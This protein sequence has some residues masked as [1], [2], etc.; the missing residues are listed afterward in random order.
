L[1][2]YGAN[3]AGLDAFI[4]AMEGCRTASLLHSACVSGILD[5]PPGSYPNSIAPGN[6]IPQTSATLSTCPNIVR[7]SAH[8]TL[9]GM[10]KP[11]GGGGI[12]DNVNAPTVTNIGLH[13]ADGTGTNMYDVEGAQNPCTI[14]SG[15]SPCPGTITGIT[16]ISVNT[17]ALESLTAGPLQHIDLTDGYVSPTLA[18]GSGCLTI[19]AGGAHPEC[20]APQVGVD[21]TG[22]WV[23]PNFAHT[24]P[25]TV[26]YVPNNGAG[27]GS[28][29]LNTYPSGTTTN[30]SA[31][32]YLQYEPQLIGSYVAHQAIFPIVLCNQVSISGVINC[33][34]T[35]T[36]GP[37]N[38]QFQYLA[39]TLAPGNTNTGQV[40]IETGANAAVNATSS[41]TTPPFAE[42]CY[43]NYAHHIDFNGMLVYGDW[44]S[45]MVGSTSIVN[46]VEFNGCYYCSFTDSQ[47]TQ[48]VD[49]GSESH[50]IYLGGN[51]L[52]I[53]NNRIECCSIRIFSGGLDQPRRW[54]QNQPNTD[55]QIGRNY[56]G[57][58]YSWL[59]MMKVPAAN[60]NF[61]GT[62]SV[63]WKNCMEFKVGQRVEVYGNIFD[64]S[65]S[66]GGQSGVCI[67]VTPNASGMPN[68]LSADMG[69]DYNIVRNYDNGGAAA[70]I[71]GPTSDGGSTFQIARFRNSHDLFYAVGK[72]NPGAAAGN[73]WGSR[74]DGGQQSC[75]AIVSETSGVATAQC[76]DSI[77]QKEPFYAVFSASGGSVVYIPT[78]NTFA[79][80]V[81][82]C[83][84]P[85]G[86]Y[87]FVQGFTTAGNNSG[88][89][90][91]GSP[92]AGFLCTSS[93]GTVLGT[94]G[95]MVG[96]CPTGSPAACEI[97]TDTN[98]PFTSAAA[99]VGAE[100]QVTQCGNAAGTTTLET[101]IASWTDASHV[102]LANACN[103]TA[104]S[105]TGITETISTLTLANSNAGA[106][107][108][109]DDNTA[110]TN[111][112]AYPILSNTP[113]S[114]NAVGNELTLDMLPGNPAFVSGCTNVPGFNMPINSSFHNVATG[115]GPLI[116]TGNGPW[117]GL[118]QSWPGYTGSTATVPAATGN[119]T[120]A[121]SVAMV[122]Y[123]WTGYD[124]QSDLT[125]NCILSNGQGG[126]SN[127]T[128]NHLGFIGPT[129]QESIYPIR[130][131]A[132]GGPTLM[133]NHAN[134]NSYFISQPLATE[135]NWNGGWDNGS[136]DTTGLGGS[137]GL[138]TERFDYDAN[139]LSTWAIFPG[140]TASDY[141]EFP[142]NPNFPEGGPGWIGGT[143]SGTI[144]LL[145]GKTPDGC[146]PVNM[147]FPTTS[148]GM[149][150]T[151]T[152]A[153][154]YGCS[155]NAVPFTVSDYHQF[156]IQPGSTYSATGGTNPS[157]DGSGD[158][159]PNI[160]L[161]DWYQTHSY[162]GA[163]PDSL[164][165]STPSA[166]PLGLV[167]Q[168]FT[169]N[170]P[171]WR[172]SLGGNSQ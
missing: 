17:T 96:G 60:P 119:G 8:A 71:R 12:Q 134:I 95:S 28:F 121:S 152:G 113:A 10:P 157:P 130:T 7:S 67:A 87:L 117:G 75:H 123:L 154:A 66:S 103:A 36:F 11:V 53:T 76:F 145:N 43:T 90:T 163:F 127:V 16:T 172:D 155:T 107:P 57:Q 166:A 4:V 147:Y 65:D 5:I 146:S 77:D 162:P 56:V 137:E 135:P 93:T 129:V 128:W 92:P 68:Y 19:D 141:I 40:L 13:N 69:F 150:F 169:K 140:R 143:C 82:F 106:A 44:R 31:Y 94:A 165:G 167:P 88:V 81:Q 116:I 74:V 164:T 18:P 41:C 84:G 80:N 102:R 14:A 2:S 32:N 85:T 29:T 21:Q 27:S 132:N 131:Y 20:L 30:I 62:P 72:N 156:E 50:G 142:N 61:S 39:T 120:W 122:T 54:Y 58:V 144:T 1:S 109:A 70:D 136:A 86:E 46:A 99:M 33:G 23:T 170:N 126:P 51:L 59:G 112:Y 111:S 108:E 79:Q 149:G 25:F 55:V 104:S 6:L 73:S 38:W 124:G 101:S 168:V 89:G 78:N 49:P 15:S 97:L 42:S 83:G 110:Q 171:P 52:K 114:Y 159:G 9:D 115:I 153:W 63:V 34:G 26:T 105:V 118:Y 139:T 158:W 161:I 160:P 98:A 37:D 100:I 133:L 24:A 47:I 3:A 35:I 45:L 125:G 22:M 138:A 148:C 48:V 64:G 91:G 151:G